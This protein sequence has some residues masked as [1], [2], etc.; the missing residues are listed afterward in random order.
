MLGRLMFFFIH[1]L[2]LPFFTFVYIFMP[3]SSIYR[4]MKTPIVKFLSHTGAFALF[5]CLL[6]LS[7]FQDKFNKSVTTPTFVG[8]D[9]NIANEV[10]KI[11]NLNSIIEVCFLFHFLFSL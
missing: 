3:C 8:K 5:L 2:L 7:A 4:D 9:T 11:S 6:V 10:F 1:A